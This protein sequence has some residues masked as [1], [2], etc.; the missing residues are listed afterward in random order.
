MA[1]NPN[2]NGLFIYVLGDESLAQLVPKE[3]GDRA[4]R[5]A[6]LDGSALTRNMPEKVP[7]VVLIDAEQA[8]GD[9]SPIERLLRHY[10]TLPVPVIV[11]GK[12]STV[13]TVVRCIKRGAED[14]ILFGEAKDK[15]PH[16]L[17]EHAQNHKLLAEVKRLSDVY[18]K[19]GRL[20]DMVGVSPAMQ[21]T[22]ATIQSIA[23]TDATV[24]IS[25]ESGTGKELVARA[26]HTLSSRSSGRFVAVNCAAIP[27]DLLE[28]ELF[29][30]EKGA[31]TSADKLHVGSCERADGGTL[32]L[33]EICEMN[34]GLQSKLLRFLQDYTFTR[35]GGTESIQVSVRVIAATNK[36]P[37]G[38]V[39]TGTLRNDLYYRLNVVPIH[40]APLRE[41]PED[42][43]VLAEH[44]LKLMC[45]KYYKYF[46]S[47]SPE[48]MRIMLS[49]PWPGNVLE[50]RNTIER[51]VVLATEEKITPKLF[52][53]R[54]RQAAMK[55]KVPSLDV[56]EALRRVENSLQSPSAGQ[57]TEDVLPFAEVEKRTILSAIKKCSGDI[58]KAA[59]KLGLS[60]AT[61][62]R[63]LDKYG[64][65]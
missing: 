6:S 8:V 32:F 54:M 18:E 2:D 16:K 45:E 7:D 41:R 34:M 52:P 14:F 40:V 4:V 43:P 55:A 17:L 35:V 23:D 38:E 44:Y 60:R 33:D 47:F 19:G 31:F 42:V 5:L 10:R 13:D 20:C 1:D 62:Y 37:L 61:L 53:D 11:I 57:D 58:S 3:I 51:I 50:L 46:A 48:A 64:V 36:D 15:L 63:K 59:R 28:S 25:G 65:R 21:D 29:G 27:K 22:Y 26:I 56:D 9:D 30:H 39:E 49:Y 24:L 12:D